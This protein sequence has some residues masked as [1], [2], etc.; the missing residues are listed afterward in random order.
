MRVLRQ[1]GAQA[2]W[3]ARETPEYDPIYDNEYAY[4]TETIW[5]R[6]AQGV[7]DTINEYI[8]E[9]SVAAPTWPPF[10]FEEWTVAQRRFLISYVVERIGYCGP[11]GPD[12]DLVIDAWRNGRLDPPSSGDGDH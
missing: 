6:L 3:I 4:V 8:E 1:E 9:E 10:P 11:N 5:E 7:A 12:S 2:D